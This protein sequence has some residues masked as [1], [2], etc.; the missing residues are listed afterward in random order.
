MGGVWEQQIR[1]V[2]SILTALLKQHS[3]NL[4]DE[5]ERIINTRPITY[6]NLGGVNSIVP[7]NPM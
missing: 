3:E 4:N 6:N 1:S 5:V 7:L 2:K